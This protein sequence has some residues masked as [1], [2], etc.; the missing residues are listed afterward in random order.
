MTTNPEGGSAKRVHPFT[1][2]MRCAKCGNTMRKRGA[3]YICDNQRRDGCARSINAA[4][5]S[6][7]IEQAVLAVFATITTANRPARAGGDGQQATKLQEQLSADRT[8][9]ERLDDD[10]YDGTIDRA[11]W[12]RQR[13]RLVDRITA[14]QHDYQRALPSRPLVTID[15]ATVADEWAGRTPAWKYEATRLLI[16][17]E[18]IHERPAGVA[19]VVRPRRGETETDYRARLRDYRR[20]LLSRRVEL[21]WHA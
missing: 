16:D 19:S 17:A 12:L 10:H 2:L 11:T 13:S 9:L 18:L 8:A 5:V 21:V 4:E 15:T 3:G 7:L 6:D 14:R 1:G 20:G